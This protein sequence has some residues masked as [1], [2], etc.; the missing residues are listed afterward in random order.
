MS[1]SAL[2][3]C[4]GWSNAGK[5]KET[6]KVAR[7]LAH[8]CGGDRL[9][10]CICGIGVHWELMR[11][12]RARCVLVAFCVWCVRACVGGARASGVMWEGAWRCPNSIAARQEQAWT[13][14]A[15]GLSN[16]SLAVGAPGNAW[17]P[18]LQ[19]P[20][21]NARARR[22]GRGVLERCVLCALPVL[23]AARIRR[24][25]VGLGAHT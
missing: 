20:W 23:T 17:G 14:V 16:V 24:S 25:G 6:P 10:P 9:Q 18:K 15:A 19:P 21:R 13:D 1:T 7:R 3:Q 8:L 2:P 12:A 11:A 5:G 4:R 22:S